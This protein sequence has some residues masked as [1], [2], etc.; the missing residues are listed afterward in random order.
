MAG[1]VMMSTKHVRAGRRPRHPDRWVKVKAIIP[2]QRKPVLKGKTD[3]LDSVADVTVWYFSDPID[4]RD[5]SAVG[6]K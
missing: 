4:V 1:I 5:K 6:C 3:L 2:G